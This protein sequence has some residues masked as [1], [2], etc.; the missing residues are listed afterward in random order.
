MKYFLIFVFSLTVIGL[1]I[2]GLGYLYL[3]NNQDFGETSLNFFEIYLRLWSIIFNLFDDEAS[4]FQN[5]FAIII[6][7]IFL[8]LHQ[9]IYASCKYI[10]VYIRDGG[11]DKYD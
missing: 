3:N 5:I 6:F 7:C 10:Y 1:L 9:L 4:F 2:Y 11:E 8:Y